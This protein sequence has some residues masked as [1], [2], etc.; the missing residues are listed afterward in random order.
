MGNP[1][2]TLRQIEKLRQEQYDTYVNERLVDQTKP[3]TDPIKRNNHPLFSRPRLRKKPRTQLQVSSLKNDCSLFSRLL[4]ASQTRDGDVD[5]VFAHEN[6]ACPPALSNMGK[7]RFRT[8]VRSGWMLG[9]LL[10]PRGNAAASPPVELKILDGAA[11]VN[12]LAPGNANTLSEY[13]LQIFLPCTTSQLEHTSRVDI[14]WDEYLTDS[15]KGGT[16]N[17]RGKGI[18]RRVEPS[19]SIPGNC[20]AFLRIDENKVELFAYLASRVAT[21]ET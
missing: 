9:N 12:M 17:R 21:T 19:S 5:K 7:M 13:A 14:V 10:P 8:Q 6:Q 16:R 15:L 18:R 1:F 4:I 2:N 3:I 20:L 11:I